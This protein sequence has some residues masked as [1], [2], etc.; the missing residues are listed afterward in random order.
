MSSDAVSSN[1]PERSRQVLPFS[2]KACVHREKHGI[3][4]WY[5]LGVLECVPQG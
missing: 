4:V 3:R 5:F 1:L 2:E